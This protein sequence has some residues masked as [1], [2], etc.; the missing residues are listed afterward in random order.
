[1]FMFL[2][3]YINIHIYFLLIFWTKPRTR[4]FN[5][6]KDQADHL[7]MKWGVTKLWFAFTS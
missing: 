5:E 4:H 6:L 3:E 1:M 7:G 2:G